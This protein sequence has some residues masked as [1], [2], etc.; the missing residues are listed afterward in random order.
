MTKYWILWNSGG[1]LA[2]LTSPSVHGTNDGSPKT[3]EEVNEYLNK[4]KISGSASHYLIVNEERTEILAEFAKSHTGWPKLM[5][6]EPSP[7]YV[8][9]DCLGKLK[10]F[11]SSE[12]INIRSI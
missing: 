8:D 1:G 3:L 2:K 10:L 4:E 7:E 11:L 9:P 12:E 6:F 5:N